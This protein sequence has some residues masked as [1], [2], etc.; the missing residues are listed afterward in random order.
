MSDWTE[1]DLAAHDLTESEIENLENEL[2]ERM[3]KYIWEEIEKETGMTREDY[4]KK[5]IEDLK[6]IHNENNRKSQES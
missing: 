2:V 5:I 3:Q 1:E 4:D 6:R